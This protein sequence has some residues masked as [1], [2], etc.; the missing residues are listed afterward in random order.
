MDRPDYLIQG[1]TA[2]LFPVLA[3]T[4]K[5]GRTTS[6]VLACISKVE[7]FGA[8][9]IASVGQRVGK[10]TT[11][12]TFT[13]I[14]FKNEKVKLKDRPDGLIV[15]QNGAKQW[16]ALVEAKVGSVDLAADQIERYREIAKE[17]GVDCI[18]TISNQFA[19]TPESHPIEE[20]RKSRSKVPVYHWS[21]MSILT[22]T[23]I[24]LNKDAVADNDQKLLLNELR[25]FLTH[26]SA[27]VKG[28]DRM[29]PEWAEINRLI[30]AGGKIPAKSSDAS[31]VL[32]AW[33]QETRDLSLILSRQTETTVQERLPRKHRQDPTERH[34]DELLTLKDVGQLRSAV[35]IPGAAA[36]LEIVAD[37]ARRT[38]DIGMTIRAPEDKV[39]SKARVNWLLRQIKT[40]KR[41][42]LFVRI[43]WPGRSET[44]Q[45]SLSDLIS[46]PSIC[47]KDKTGLKVLSFHVFMAR[48]LG[49][50]FTQQVNFIKE[51]EDVVPFFYREVGQNLSEWR[52]PA[53]RIKEDKPTAGDVS[54]AA[55]QDESEEGVDE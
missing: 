42:E 9:L 30:S 19:T 32:D 20:V 40:E 17:Q 43:G 36:P 53:P 11:L 35:D 34:R 10:R 18:I 50:K 22:T 54:V 6:I 8:E 29:P 3:T 7:E 46:D 13:E 23:D 16:R 41:G 1:E 31:I 49:A 26:E 37:I 21:W 27:G 51:L 33:H 2:R 38:I 4:S 28:F 44:T 5:E 12:N 47:E 39:S 52:K 15:M 55:L 24:L 45:F 14:V 25:R 48:R